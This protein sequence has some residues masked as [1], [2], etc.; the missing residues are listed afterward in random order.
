MTYSVLIVDDSAITRGVLKK[1]LSLADIGISE[2]LEAANGKEALELLEE[3]KVDLIILDINMPVMDGLEFA[4]R[5]KSSPE[6]ADI[7]AL[8]MSSDGSKQRKSELM[9][10][11][12]KGYLRK[13]TTPEKLKEIIAPLIG[14]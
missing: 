12:I 14:E 1:S 7:P 13:P 4:K 9:D 3:S 11:G 10:C 2:V 5:L 8:T 6:L